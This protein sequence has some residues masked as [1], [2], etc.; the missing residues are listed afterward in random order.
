MNSVVN[1]QTN[2]LWSQISI[3]YNYSI[4]YNSKTILNVD[5]C[6]GETVY[7]ITN[8]FNKENIFFSHSFS[9]HFYV[10]HALYLFYLNYIF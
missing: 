4:G 9:L 8:L 3:L 1:F 6:L 10:L 7:Y 5:K 2:N